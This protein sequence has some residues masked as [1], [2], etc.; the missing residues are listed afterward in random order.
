MKSMFRLTFLLFA[1][2]INASILY[3][4]NQQ[5]AVEYLKYIDS[6][7]E[8][9]SSDIMSYTSAVA[10]GKS[11]RKVEKI[12]VEL[13]RQL[14]EA[15]RNI[16]SMKPFNGD[17][18]L[19]D[20]I[21]NYFKVQEIVLNED[22]GKILDLEDIAEQSFDAME[23]YLLAKEKASEKLEQAHQSSYV[24]YK[25]FADDNRIN[26]IEGSSRLSEKMAAADE[27][28]KYYNRVYLLFFKSYK[29]EAYMLDAISRNDVSAIEQT[30]VALLNSATEDLKNIGPTP[31]F[32]GDITL[33]TACQKMLKFYETEASTK[34]A[35][36]TDY[37]LSKERFEKIKSAFEM[38][39]AKNRTQSDVDLY[40][41]AVAEFNDTVNKSNKINDELNKS[42][43]SLIESWNKACDTFMDK[44]TPRYK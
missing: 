39:N 7:Y 20:S 40:N 23:A 9:V 25:R 29:N 10:H 8:S 26:L 18:S 42:R 33:K 31:A 35:V 2:F 28:F 5:Q 1:F 3:G 30:R 41:K 15:N 13:M 12:R 19:R 17:H 34:A 37:N 14:R 21:A 36:F 44:H 6:Q 16:R 11:A 27:V 32:K 22:F 24:N 38:K 4:Q 43:Q